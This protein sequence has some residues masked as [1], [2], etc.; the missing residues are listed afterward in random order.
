[1]G[2]VLFEL[3]PEEIILWP[4]T[5]THPM[6]CCLNSDISLI[7]FAALKYALWL[8]VTFTVTPLFSHTT[9][10]SFDLLIY[11]ISYDFQQLLL[12]GS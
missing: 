6:W 10:Y 9:S 1:M 4:Q 7:A 5:A 3:C 11:Y 12:Q 2:F 8:F